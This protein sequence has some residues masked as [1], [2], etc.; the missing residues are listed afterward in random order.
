MIFFRRWNTGPRKRR[1]GAQTAAPSRR[2]AP[3]GCSTP[4]SSRPRFA[5]TRARRPSSLREKRP[6][7]GSLA[8]PARVKAAGSGS[9][10]AE[11]RPALLQHGA[12]ALARVGALPRAARGLVE[13]GVGDALAGGDRALNGGLDARQRQR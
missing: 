5:C 11:V 2:R 8:G 4:I 9:L 10:A 13:V 7:H 1:P 3:T 12:P 6:E